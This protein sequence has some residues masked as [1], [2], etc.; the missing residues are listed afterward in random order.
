[1][2][3]MVIETLR[4]STTAHTHPLPVCKIFFREGGCLKE[5]TFRILK[6][7][8]FITVNTVQILIK[9]C[10]FVGGGVS[11]NSVLQMYFLLS[12]GN[13]AGI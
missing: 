1:M 7:F 11:S 2:K 5:L 3:P 4:E 13:D 10:N 12:I 9:N 8:Y 6:A